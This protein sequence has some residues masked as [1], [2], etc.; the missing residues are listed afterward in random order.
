MTVVIDV[1]S[2]QWS[3]YAGTAAVQIN[4]TALFWL[5]VELF[6]QIAFGP[7]IIW[8]RPLITSLL[9]VQ[10]VAAEGYVSPNLKE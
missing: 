9:L 1:I 6:L 7:R 3:K 10:H 5:L 8:V 4:C 2:M